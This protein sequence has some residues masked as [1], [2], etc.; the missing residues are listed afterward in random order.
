[1]NWRMVI[2]YLF[3]NSELVINHVT[4]LKRVPY[5]KNIGVNIISMC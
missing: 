2:Q 4:I 3:V 1:M 5:L